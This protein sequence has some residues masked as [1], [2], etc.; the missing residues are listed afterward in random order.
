MATGSGQPG[1]RDGLD[2][3]T[4][5]AHFPASYNSLHS[6]T[7]PVRHIRTADGAELADTFTRE[8]FL[9][10][11]SDFSVFSVG[12]ACVIQVSADPGMFWVDMTSGAVATDTAVASVSQY[13]WIRVKI[14]AGQDPDVWLFTKY[15]NN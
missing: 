6:K 11:T 12:A 7:E 2:P 3:T 14:V 9:G 15:P 1:P 8:Y 13:P 10:N 5:S 4:S